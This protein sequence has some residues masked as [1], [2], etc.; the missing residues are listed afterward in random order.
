MEIWD[1]LFQG[2]PESVCSLSLIDTHILLI[3]R[4]I[5]LHLAPQVDQRLQIHGFSQVFERGKRLRMDGAKRFYSLKRK[6][7]LL[8]YSHLKMPLFCCITA[9]LTAFPFF[10]LPFT[11]LDKA[12]STCYHFFSFVFSLALFFSQGM[13]RPSSTLPKEGKNA[14]LKK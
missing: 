2:C 7:Y 4:A 14:S 5:I 13:T 3:E 11:F 1:K 10:I 9:F 8:K 12:P 6:A